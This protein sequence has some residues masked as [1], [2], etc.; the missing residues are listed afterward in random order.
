VTAADLEAGADGR[1]FVDA[2]YLN[3]ESKIS[4]AIKAIV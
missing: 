3:A 1:P 2:I 4:S